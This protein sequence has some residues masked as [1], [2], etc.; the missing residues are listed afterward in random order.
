M[1]TLGHT[2]NDI[3]LPDQTDQTDHNYKPTNL[4]AHELHDAA[5]P[6]QTKQT[7]QTT[8]PLALTIFFKYFD[9]RDQTIKPEQATDANS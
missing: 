5:F 4:L 8:A 9:S 3:A 2:L 1:S 6:D 7:K